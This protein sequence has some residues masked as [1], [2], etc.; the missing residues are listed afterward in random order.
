MA[1]QLRAYTIAFD[2]GRA[3]RVV[4]LTD[5]GAGLESALGR[6][7]GARVTFVLDFGHASEHLHEMARVW[8]GETDAAAKG[9]WEGFWYQTRQAA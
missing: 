8:H 3:E 9:L 5:G 4:A 6:H 2:V 1:E 7:F